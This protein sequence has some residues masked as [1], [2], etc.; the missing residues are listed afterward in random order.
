MGGS[1][2]WFSRSLANFACVFPSVR[3][4]PLPE[5]TFDAFKLIGRLRPKNLCGFRIVVVLCGFYGNT[6]HKPCESNETDR[7]H[8]MA[9]PPLMHRKG[10]AGPHD[11][12]RHQDNHGCCFICALS[13]SRGGADERAG[14]PLYGGRVNAKALGNAAYTFTGAL[15]LVQGKG[16]SGRHV[17]SR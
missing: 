12:Q 3:N 15:T 9:A 6:G 7:Y 8:V 4:V 1:L 2:F 11:Q 17:T 13:A 5:Q 10:H 14:D 16:S